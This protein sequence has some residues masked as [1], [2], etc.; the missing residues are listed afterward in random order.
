MP[1]SK[2]IQE[3]VDRISRTRENLLQSVSGLSESQLNHKAEETGWS[4][5]DILNHVS[6]ADE[7]SAKLTS[8]MLKR[9]RASTLPPDPSPDASEIHSMDQIFTKMNTA[10]F[11]APELVKPHPHAQVDESLS[12]LK[13]ARERMLANIEQLDGFDL[14][15]LTYP[16]PFAGELNAYQWILAAGAHEARH[17]EQ[18]NRMKSQPGFPG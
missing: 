4:I 16:H 13:V 9:A 15:G 2:K 12:R 7:A 14:S 6:L 11:Q 1:L 3:L 18:I 17:A 10:K 8:N 5:G